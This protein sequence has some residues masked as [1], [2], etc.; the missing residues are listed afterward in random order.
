MVK[1]ILGEIDK[2][3][4]CKA[5][6]AVL[7]APRRLPP[8]P[9]PSA[10]AKLLCLSPSPSP[11]LSAL[12]EQSPATLRTISRPP[13]APPPAAP[14]RAAGGVRVAAGTD[15]NP[16]Y[17]IARMVHRGGAPICTYIYI[18][19][20]NIYIYILPERSI[21]A[22]RPLRIALAGLVPPRGQGVPLLQGAPRPRPRPRA[23]PGPRPGTCR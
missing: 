11:P 12:S 21:E 23:H 5:H 4:F 2:I 8:R 22:V 18:C 14:R 3:D 10:P 13:H 17:G 20:D 15:P 7:Q 9:H 19:M 16:L 6:R 1:T